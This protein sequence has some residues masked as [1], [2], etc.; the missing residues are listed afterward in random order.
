MMQEQ[1][2]TDVLNQYRALSQEAERYE[3]QSHHLESESSNMR[4]E[5]LTKDSEMRRLREKIDS[6]DRQLQEVC[7]SLSS[8]HKYVS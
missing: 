6:L 8:Q 7:T 3:T 4:L 1:E 5:L 2:R